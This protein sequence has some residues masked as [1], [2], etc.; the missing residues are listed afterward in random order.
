[1]AALRDYYGLDKHP[2]K[3]HE[4]YQ[5]LGLVEDDLKQAMGLDVDGVVPRNTMFGFPIEGWKMW[6][7]P[8][9]LEVLVPGGFVT[10]TAANGDILI[11]PEGDPTVPPSG[12]HAR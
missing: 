7:L 10:T 8:D 4:P 11:Y 5:M 1:M 12:P 3:V 6:R 2:V 9:G